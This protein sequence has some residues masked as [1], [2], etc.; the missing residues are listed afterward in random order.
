MKQELV[1]DAKNYPELN[2]TDVDSLALWK[3]DQVMRGE[4]FVKFEPVVKELVE[5]VL[6]AKVE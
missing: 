5:E 4:G 2:K 1:D 3:Y 6:A